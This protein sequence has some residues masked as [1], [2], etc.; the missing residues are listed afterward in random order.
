ML[1]GGHVPHGLAGGRIHRDQPSVDRADVDL[2][3]PHG[4]AA[5]HDVAAGIDR[6][7]ARHLRIELPQLLARLRLERV[8]LA[9]G[10]GHIDDAI[11]DDRRGFLS[12]TRIEVREPG[13]PEVLDGFGVDALQRAEALFGVVPTVG[14]PLAG[15]CRLV[16]RQK[17]RGIHCG[18]PERCRAVPAQARRQ[19]LRRS[20]CCTPQSAVQGHIPH[21]SELRAFRTPRK[22]SS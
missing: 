2:A 22:T 4:D 8:D 18:E 5:I 21:R 14:H 12:A 11:D 1:D 6:P 19:C 15:V 7:L 9:P 17:T 20:C 10:R 13:E 3:V 16:R